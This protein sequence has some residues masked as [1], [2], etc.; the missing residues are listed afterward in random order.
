MLEEALKEGYVD[1]E[2][3]PRC[4]FYLAQSYRDSQK[5]EE[6]FKNYLKRAEMD[7]FDQEAYM[8]LLHLAGDYQELEA[9]KNKEI[10]EKTVELV[11]LDY[12]IRAHEKCPHRREAIRGIYNYYNKEKQYKMCWRLVRDDI[13]NHPNISPYDLVPSSS[14]YSFLF[15]ED[16]AILAHNAKDSASFKILIERALADPELQKPENKTHLD[17]IVSH[18]KWFPPEEQKP[19]PAMTVAHPS[20]ALAMMKGKSYQEILSSFGK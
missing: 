11:K 20:N 15:N 5:R 8:S 9:V 2:D 14:D 7:G 10:S 13:L 16:M 12:F 19:V 1:P 18:K 3:V 17:R 6:S 4:T